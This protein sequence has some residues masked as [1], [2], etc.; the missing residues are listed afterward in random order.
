MKTYLWNTSFG[1]NPVAVWETAKSESEA[2]KSILLKLEMTD[3]SVR[4]KSWFSNE[5]MFEF[6]FVGPFSI[7]KH[8]IGNWEEMIKQIIEKPASE[9]FDKE[10]GSGFVSALDG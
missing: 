5:N 10:R 1:F 8:N 2:R 4:T 9:V 7:Y 6:V 3:L